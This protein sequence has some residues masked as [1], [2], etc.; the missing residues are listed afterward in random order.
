MHILLR[1]DY[2][3]HRSLYFGR[4]VLSTH[5][6]FFNLTTANPVRTRINMV[7][8]YYDGQMIPGTNV[9]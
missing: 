8:E 9:A 5:N 6:I 4:A 7:L 3:R 1:I 2:D